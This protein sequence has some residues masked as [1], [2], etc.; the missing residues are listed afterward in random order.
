MKFFLNEKNYLCLNC[1]LR[2]CLDRTY[3]AE[4]ENRK[5]CNKIIFKCMNSAVGP[6]F[7]EKVTEKWNL[8][9]HKQCTDTLFKDKKSTSAA[10]KKK[11]KKAETRWKQNVDAISRIQTLPES[12]ILIRMILSLFLKQ[13]K[14]KRMILSLN[15]NLS[16]GLIKCWF[17][18]IICF[19]AM[20]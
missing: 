13:K 7:N 4:T 10:T 11:K 17:I 3:F 14:K 12:W 1:N 20:D 2:V 16:N 8:W 5:H 15:E 18:I 6:I 9:V 19:V